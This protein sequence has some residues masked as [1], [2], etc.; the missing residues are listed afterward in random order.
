MRISN[1]ETMTQVMREYSRM[2]EAFQ[3]RKIWSSMSDDELWGEVCL[4]ILSSN[5]PY[6][7]ALSASE[8]LH[9]SKYLDPD[10]IVGCSD[11]VRI[12]A[13]ELS[14]QIYLPR[15]KDGSRRKYRFP[16]IRA[17]DIVNAAKT[18]FGEG[19]GLSWILESCTSE[20]E[21]RDLLVRS[22]HGIGLKEASHFLRNIGY[23]NSLAI[24]DSHVMAFLVE[25]GAISTKGIKAVTPSLYARLERILQ[26]MCDDWSLNLSV[27]DMAIWQY[28][29]GK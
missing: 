23:S 13:S 15:R 12:I 3:S 14:R 17:R 4:C 18:L 22:I 21:A 20:T 16:N 24:I 5:V 28:M 1:S 27:L 7:L 25:V 9:S 29:R 26:N 8:H 19:R 6:E 10:W 2:S 11:S